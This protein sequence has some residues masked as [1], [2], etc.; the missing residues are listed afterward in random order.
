MIFFFDTETS[1]LIKGEQDMPKLLQISYLIFSDDGNLLLS[2]NNYFKHEY[3]KIPQGAIDIHG[4]TDEFL[5]ENGCRMNDALYLICSLMNVC[6][7]I[8][9]HN[10]SFDKKVLQNALDENHVNFQLDD[11]KFFCTM[12]GTRKI[13][14]A[15]NQKGKPK[16]PSLKELYSY[17]FGKEFEGA[18]NSRND[19]AATSASFWYLIQWGELNLLD[20]MN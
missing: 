9:C 6:D 20:V 15:V 16:Q 4:L 14:G 17:C 11:K 3:F 2:G 5:F 8:V 7:L 19:V 13:V 18:H 1:G 12:D 10:V